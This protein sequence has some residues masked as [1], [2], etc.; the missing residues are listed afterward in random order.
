MSLPQ[1]LSLDG[2]QRLRIA[3]IETVATLRGVHQGVTEALLPADR[4]LAL[5]TIRG[6]VLELDVEIDPA[7]AQLV[8]LNVL[9]SPDGQER[10]SIT[11]FNMARASNPGTAARQEIVLDG[12]HSSILSDVTVRPPERAELRWSKGD[13]LELRI[14]I[15]RSVVEVFVNG[16]QYLAMRVYPGR[17]DSVGVSLR[18]RGGAATLNKLD[19]WQ[20]KSIWP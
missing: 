13:T 1:R 9:R 8:E 20:V 19:A 4:E 17:E 16:Q 14:F 11:L 6:N 15:D 7:D 5:D 12:S 18:A 10:T 3:P 2:T